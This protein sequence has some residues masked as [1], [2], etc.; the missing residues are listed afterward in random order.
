MALIRFLPP[1]NKIT[2][3][4][5]V[6]IDA[7]NIKELSDKLIEA[8]GK[9][10]DLLIDSKGQLSQNIVVLVNRRNAHTLEGADTVLNRDSEVI[11]LPHIYGG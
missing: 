8:Y 1:I 4:D 10:I 9:K 3:I 2:E 6:Y 7:Q 11:I 5:S